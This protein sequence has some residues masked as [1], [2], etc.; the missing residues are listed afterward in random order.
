MKTGEQH[1]KEKQRKKMREAN[2][3]KKLRNG[4]EDENNLQW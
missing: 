1:A 3:R 2:K 4:G